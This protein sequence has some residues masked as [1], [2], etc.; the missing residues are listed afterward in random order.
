MCVQSE[1][2]FIFR[3]TV[4]LLCDLVERHAFYN[5]I[6]LGGKGL[7][8]P[9]QW[10]Y[11]GYPSRASCDPRRLEILPL[12]IITDRTTGDDRGDWT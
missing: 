8:L 7:V 6:T 5:Y 10:D 3:L 9:Q 4:Y 12:E 1:R 2:S 11:R